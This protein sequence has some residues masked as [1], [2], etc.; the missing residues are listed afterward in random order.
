MTARANMEAR[1]GALMDGDIIGDAAVAEL[2][3]LSAERITPEQLAGAADAAMA[4]ALP[5]PEA[6]DAVD[7]CGTG[8]DGRNTYNISTATAIVVA[9]CSVR[10][11]KHGNRAV[12]SRAGSADVLEALGVETA[13]RPEHCAKIFEQTGI[14]FLYAP[15]FHPG[16]AT[17]APVRKALNRRTIFN[18]LGPLCNPAR[19]KRQL[20]GTYDASLNAIMAEAAELLGRTQAMVVHGDDGTDEC[21]ITGISHY[22]RLNDGRFS[23]S[24]L[25]PEDVGLPTH[26]GRALVGGDAHQNARALRDVLGGLDCPYTDAVLLNSAALLH[27][28]GA[29]TDLREGVTLARRAITSGDAARKLAQL[30]EASHA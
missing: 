21:S 23:F 26:A 10:V 14:T 18:L 12:S 19:V 2:H 22:V 7:C 4:R 13:T 28:A 9:A 29:V 3:L 27:V 1:I 30:I 17:V 16:F 8:G 24:T 5:F 20:I 6:P 11:A 25:M 15:L